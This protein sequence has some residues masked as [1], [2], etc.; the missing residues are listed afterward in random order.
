MHPQAIWV[1]RN[2]HRV[3]S[4]VAKFARCT[5]LGPFF[6]N[7][8]Y[9]QHTTYCLWVYTCTLVLSLTWKVPRA[10]HSNACFKEMWWLHFNMFHDNYLSL[11][12]IFSVFRLSNTI[13]GFPILVVTCWYSKDLRIFCYIIRWNMPDNLFIFYREIACLYFA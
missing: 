11:E 3:V 13:L 6:T 2:L 5:L 1:N 12:A 9:V 10:A 4:H 7:I 8:L